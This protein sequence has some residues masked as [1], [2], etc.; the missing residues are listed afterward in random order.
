MTVVALTEVDVVLAIEHAL[1]SLFG[2]RRHA[3]VHGIHV[4]QPCASEVF[5]VAVP[6]HAEEERVDRHFEF[7][8]K[9][10]N[11]T[12]GGPV[13]YCGQDDQFM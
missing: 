8:R 11:D 4:A 2:S 10:L 1:C 12:F 5:P 6:E 3:T 7:I 9:V 13:E